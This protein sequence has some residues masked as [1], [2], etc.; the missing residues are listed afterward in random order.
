MRRENDRQSASCSAAVSGATRRM[1]VDRVS[2]LKAV[3]KSIYGQRQDVRIGGVLT[4]SLHEV[5]EGTS[6]ISI[7]PAGLAMA[8]FSLSFATSFFYFVMRAT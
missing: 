5:V 3:L 6:N 4:P 8:E 1:I 7:Q 2:S